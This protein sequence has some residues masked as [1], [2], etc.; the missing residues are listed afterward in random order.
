MVALTSV[1]Q[2]YAAH[3][4]ELTLSAVE[5]SNEARHIVRAGADGFVAVYLA[6]AGASGKVIVLNV[7]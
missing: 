7:N 4:A 6:E 3:V 5:S 2:Y 1:T